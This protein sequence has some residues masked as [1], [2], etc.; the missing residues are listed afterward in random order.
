MV[1]RSRGGF[2]RMIRGSVVAQRRR[3]GK[4]ACRCA[5]GEQLHESAAL[6]YS[7]DGRNRTVMLATEQ[8]AAVTAAVQ[9]Y[10]SA[11][12]KLEAQGNAGLAALLSRRAA[13]RGDR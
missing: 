9:R 2:P 3:C 8:V 11:Q 7:Q 4:A 13:A 1:E 5:D 12:A 6:S 10:R